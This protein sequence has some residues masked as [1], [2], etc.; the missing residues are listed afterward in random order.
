MC[1][2]ARADTSIRSHESRMAAPLVQPTVTADYATLQLG[3]GDTYGIALLDGFGAVQLLP[4][5]RIVI[6][7]SQD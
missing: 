5:L 7:P 1:S 6:I 4:L 2:I 3:A